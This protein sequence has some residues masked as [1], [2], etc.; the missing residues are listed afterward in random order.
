LERGT[1]IGNVL[2]NNK[3]EKKK[4]NDEEEE[5]KKYSKFSLA[6]METQ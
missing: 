6:G 5:K 2:S 3:E 4:K 1:N